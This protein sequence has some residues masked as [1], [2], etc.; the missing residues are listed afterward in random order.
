M[1]LVR[2]ALVLAFFVV[3]GLCQ[4]CFQSAVLPEMVWAQVAG[5]VPTAYGLPFT[6]GCLVPAAGLTKIASHGGYVSPNF[7]SFG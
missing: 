6:D 7:R 4:I 1:S 5:C 2:S 3:L